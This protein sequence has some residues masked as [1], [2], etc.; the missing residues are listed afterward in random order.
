MNLPSRAPWRLVATLACLC[1]HLAFSV[2]PA[3][4]GKGEGRDGGMWNTLDQSRKIDL[5]LAIFDGFNL[6]ESIYSI[7]V[8][9]EYSICAEVLQNV[10][11]QTEA[12]FQAATAGEIVTALDAFYADPANR[13]IPVAWG[14]WVVVRKAGGDPTVGRFIKELRKLH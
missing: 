10:S 4:G 1:L 12:Y 13:R 2:G 7:I 8:T 3:H 11:R 6:S 14:L 5:V 9:G